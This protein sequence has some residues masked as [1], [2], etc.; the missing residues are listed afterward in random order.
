MALVVGTLPTVDTTF[1]QSTWNPT[2]LV[3]TEAFQV[4]DDNDADS[5]VRL[6]FGETIDRSLTYERTAGRFTFDDDL[7]I[8]GSVE[9]TGTA[10]GD[11]LYISRSFSGAGLTD[12]DTDSTDKLLWDASTGRFSCGTDQDTDWS[13]TGALQTAFDARY[14]NVSGDTMTGALTINNALLTL[15]G[16]NLF[17]DPGGEPSVLSGTN[18]N[19]NL[20]TVKVRNNHAY[21]GMFSDSI[22][23]FQIFYVGNPDQPQFVGSLEIGNTV[24]NLDIAGQYAYIARTN[25]TGDD[26][27]VV[28]IGDPS[29][30]VAVGGIDFAE[31]VLSVDIDGTYA[32]VG[33]A[34]SFYVI[35]ISNPTN[36]TTLGSITIGATVNALKVRGQY[37]YIGHG[38][39]SGDEFRI[40]DISNPSAPAIVGGLNINIIQ[41]IDVSGKY[42]YIAIV[43][44]GGNDMRIIDISDPE[45]PTTVGG[46]EFGKAVNNVRVVGDY[47][48]V[49]TALGTGDEFAYYDVSD[50]AN[51]VKKGGIELGVQSRGIDVNGK[52]AYLVHNTHADVEFRILDVGG[53]HAPGAT[54]GALET[55]T[56]SVGDSADI[57][58][59]LSVGGG[60]TVGSDGIYSQGAVRIFGNSGSNTLDALSIYNFTGSKLFRISNAGVAS[61][62]SLQGFG[63]T[64]CSN[65]TT[66]KLLWDATTG[67]FSCGTDQSGGGGGITQN[68]GDERYVNVSGDTMTG[69]LNID[70]T[71]G[72]QSTVGLETPNTI[73]GAQVHAQGLLTSSGQVVITNAIASATSEGV[74][75]PSSVVSD[76]SYGVLSWSNPGNATASDDSY[77][78][79]AVGFDF[80]SEYLSSTNYGFSLPS[81]AII[82]GIEVRVERK[83]STGFA[84]DSSA[85]IIKGGTV[86][87]DENATYMDWANTDTIVTY[88]GSANLWG[89]TWSASDINASNFGFAIAASDS[90]D[91]STLSVDHITITI[92]YTDSGKQTITATGGKLGIRTASPE[93]ELEVV[94]TASGYVLH[95]QDA[96]R[97]SGTLSIDG[98]SALRSTLDVIGNATF[99]EDL[100]FGDAIG[101]AITVNSGTWTFA[102]DTN[103][104]LS[105]GVNGLSFD[106]STLSIDAFN[107]RVGIGTIA[108]TTTL[109]TI[110]TISGSSIYTNDLIN[111]A[112]AESG[113]VLVTQQTG[114]PQ[115]LTQTSALIWYL[116]GDISTG[117]EQG[118]VVT[119]PQN[120]VSKAVHLKVKTAP[121]G[122]ALIVDINRDGTSIFSTRPQINASSTTGGDSAIFSFTGLTEGD[123]L[124]VDVDQVGSGTAGN[125]LTIMLQGVRKY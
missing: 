104:V 93:T 66:D 33:T 92:Y 102:N 18:L 95:A 83:S 48:Y 71:G 39:I 89:T 110:G 57:T 55:T 115:W 52:Y 50:P 114:G 32:Y 69:A 77:V 27:I 8:E 14:V 68:S 43:S 49:S 106:T 40:V 37:A 73:S 11:A 26:F 111:S 82:N 105:G 29:S 91:S 59:S 87:G 44:T 45:S 123:E 100:T 78:T 5:D 10:S 63:L 84:Y 24:N 75:S 108:P 56:L 42:A 9:F 85:R 107:D 34:T 112:A 72:S 3:N 120:F 70:V 67:T 61:G 101:D 36:P 31:N 13:G 74:N 15:S 4:I 20:K 51:I 30:P 76:D 64:D 38:T 1:A 53:I 65:G 16:G 125:G 62:V 121:T 17:V 54:I 2:L 41:D 23:D 96:L 21:I 60:I 25:T 98:A 7:R 94:G 35:D 58:T 118:A 119:V 86:T 90:S 116:D 28:D 79:S 122:Q 46:L 103:F 6:T 88:G 47:L 99:D 124:S 12:C 22:D 80:S 117:T 113:S 109:E 19:A 81:S 97:G